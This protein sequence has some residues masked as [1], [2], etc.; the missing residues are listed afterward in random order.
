MSVETFEKLANLCDSE[1]EHDLV[2]DQRFNQNK[3]P[4]LDK[5]QRLAEFAGI[6]MGDGHIQHRSDSNPERDTSTYFISVT[7]NEAEKNLIEHTKTLLHEI[8]GLTPKEYEKDG[9]CIRIVLH[10][11]E[12]VRRLRNI[13]LEAGNKK[14]NQISVPAWIKKR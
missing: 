7:L 6:I 2:P 9:R 10:S 8:T 13:G 11:K 5:D 3:V 14:E 12:L 1:I 4:E